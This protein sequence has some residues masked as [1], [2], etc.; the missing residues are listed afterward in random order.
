LNQ[1][2]AKMQ[3]LRKNKENRKRKRRKGKKY[4]MAPGKPLGPA[5]VSATAQLT[6]SRT[7]T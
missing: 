5:P 6:P 1:I 3:K 4:K 2:E 7:G